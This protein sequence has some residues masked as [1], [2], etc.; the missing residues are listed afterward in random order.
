MNWILDKYKTRNETETDVSPFSHRVLFVDGLNTYLRN[1]SANPALDINGDHCGGYVGFLKSIFSVIRQFRITRCVIVFDG[2]GG[3]R[4]RKQ[5]FPEYKAHRSGTITR[6]NRTY[7]FENIEQ[8]QESS[9]KQLLMLSKA[10]EYLPFQTFSV[11]Y[12]EADD[13]IAYLALRNPEDTHN[14][15]LSSDKD[16][17]QLTTT[18]ISVYSPSKKKLYTPQVVHDEYGVYPSNMIW[19]RAIEGDVS[20]NIPGIKGI[21]KTTL[22]KYVPSLSNTTTMLDSQ[23]LLDACFKTPGKYINK[24]TQKLYEGLTNGLVDRNRVLMDLHNSY[25]SSNSKLSVAHMYDEF[26]FVYSK[27]EFLQHLVDTKIINLF[28]NI[29]NWLNEGLYHILTSHS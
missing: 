8:E 14:F 13:I 23:I 15:I 2:P 3:A 21:K 11:E 27:M 20:D 16:F 24:T 26:S 25:I 12:V 18:N 28:P 29:D 22:L 4:R 10:L 9:K 5:L 6:V 1:F 17:L 19:V 7:E